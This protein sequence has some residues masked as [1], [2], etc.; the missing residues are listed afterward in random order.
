MSLPPSEHSDDVSETG[1][2]GIQSV[3]DQEKIANNRIAFETFYSSQKLC[4]V[5]DWQICLERLRLPLAPCFRVRLSGTSSEDV[6]ATL[7]LFRQWLPEPVLWC[8]GA[9]RLSCPSVVDAEGHYVSALSDALAEAQHAGRLCRQETASMLPVQALKIEP[10]HVVLDLCAAPGSKTLQLLDAM[11]SCEPSVPAGV[12]VANDLKVVRLKKLIDRTRRVP[13]TTLLVTCGDARRYPNLRA[14]D[15]TKVRFDRIICD[16]PCSGD[17]TVRKARSLLE[18]WNPRAGLSHHETQLTIL[19]RSIEMLAPGGILAYS[20]CS[21]NP[22]ECE[23]VVAAALAQIGGVVEII[24]I[25]VPGLSLASGLTSWLVPSPKAD[26]VTYASWTD[27]PDEEKNVGRVCRSMFPPCT[28]SASLEDAEAISNQL[29]RCGRLLPVHDDGGCFF[30]A[31]FHR[32]GEGKASLQRGDCMFLAS[33]DT[34]VIVRGLGSGR[35]QGLIRVAYPDGSSYHVR[36]EELEW[37]KQDSSKIQ[38]E[39]GEEETVQHHEHTAKEAKRKTPML[40]QVSVSDWE[41]V[42]EFYGLT[43]QMF[44]HFHVRPL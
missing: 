27:V 37:P 19:R 24:P 29:T 20:T 25:E 7:A 23:A 12:L 28:Y 15:T 18:S 17:G 32:V 41:H 42:A 43:E 34:K 6:N 4:S 3:V 16:V 26:G 38:D 39:E 2:P 33:A 36:R 13:A 9:Y 22:V 44:C 10:H 40:R 5:N 31:L 8:P 35:Y 14:S 11:H 21:L 30:L 1:E